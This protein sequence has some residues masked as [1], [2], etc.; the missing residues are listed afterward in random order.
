MWPSGRSISNPI[1]SFYIKKK[2]FACNHLGTWEWSV[3]GGDRMEQY[4]PSFTEWLKSGTVLATSDVKDSRGEEGRVRFSMS[5]IIP[6]NGNG[7]FG[8]LVSF[9]YKEDCAE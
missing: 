7:S 4:S 9:H 2:Y 6:G 8:Y 1:P 5:C 3:A